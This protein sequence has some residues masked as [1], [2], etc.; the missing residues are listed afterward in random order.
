M[1][2]ANLFN[3]YRHS[4]QKFDAKKLPLS[5][6]QSCYLKKNQITENMFRST[7]VLLAICLVLSQL[8]LTETRS[9]N[10]EELAVEQELAIA[11]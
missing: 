3:P 10:Y 4:V 2:H 5:I 11:N 8:D 7:L 6:F 1:V 9:I